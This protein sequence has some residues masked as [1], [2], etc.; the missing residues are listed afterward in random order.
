MSTLDQE[1]F[2]FSEHRTIKKVVENIIKLRTLSKGKSFKNLLLRD[3]RNNN[4][5]LNFRSLKKASIE[6]FKNDK[7][8]RILF[9]LRSVEN[10]FDKLPSQNQI[11]D[12]F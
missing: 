9:Q 1:S 7:R 6:G 8:C 2:F 3:E 11:F 4:F 5:S 12:E 10:L